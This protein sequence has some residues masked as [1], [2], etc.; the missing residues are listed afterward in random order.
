MRKIFSDKFCPFC[1]LINKNI[2]TLGPYPS[3]PT[4]KIQKPKIVFQ[5]PNLIVTP[6]IAPI[7]PFHLLAITR[8]HEV[9][10]LSYF[11]TPEFNLLK[12]W[13]I[14]YIYKK[15][16][17]HPLIFEHGGCSSIDY[18]SACIQHAHIHFVPMNH[19]TKIEILKK[20]AHEL[21][22]SV[23]KENVKNSNYLMINA[24]EDNYLFWPDQKNL[25]QFFRFI[26]S[27]HFHEVQRHSWQK[28]LTNEQIEKSMYWYSLVTVDQ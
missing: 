23:G 24:I 13:V 4:I 9:S 20:I 8:M 10:F 1:E 28:C 12:N 7:V 11:N 3:S 16:T 27:E 15:T 14:D 17:L 22:V 26:I 18:S 6:D 2:I 25:H 19:E 21:N 5:T